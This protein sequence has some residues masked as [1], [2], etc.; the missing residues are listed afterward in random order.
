MIATHVLRYRCLSLLLVLLSSLSLAAEP[1]KSPSDNRDYR[2]LELDNGLKLLLIHSPDA[3]KAAASLE[4]SVGSGADPEPHAGLAHFLEHMLFLGTKKYPEAG[5]YQAYISQHGGRHNAFTAHDRTNYFFDIDQQ[6]LEPAL[7]RFAQFFISPLFTPEYVDRERHAV[8]SEYQS[9]LKDDG[10]RGY[11]TLRAALNPRH[12]LANFSVGSLETLTDHPG[13]PLLTALHRFYQQHYHANRMGLVIQGPQSLDQLQQWA[14][15]KFSAIPSGTTAAPTTREP[16]FLP[17]TLPAQLEVV[18]L[19]DIYELSATFPV[20]PFQAYWDKKPLQYLGALLGHEGTTSLLAELKR[21]G[22]AQGLSAGPGFDYADSATFTIHIDLTPAGL[23]QRDAVVELLFAT[24]ARIR[25]EDLQPWRYDEERLISETAFRF[26]EPAK[27]LYDVL[28]LA[29]KLRERPT[30][31]LLHGDYLYREFD[32]QL[33]DSYLQRLTP[34]NLL[35]TVTAQGLRG[36]QLEPRYQVSYKLQPISTERLQRWRQA[37][38]IAAIQLPEANPFLAEDFSLEPSSGMTIPQLIQEQPGFRLW[39]QQDDDF[40]VPRAN[41]YFTFRSPVAN[42]SARHHLMTALFVELVNDQLN[43]YLYPAS[44]AGFQTSLY[45]HIR[46][47][48]LRLSGYSDKQSPLLEAVVNQLSQLKIAPERL[49]IIREEMRQQ[50]QNRL[51]ATPYELAF[52]EL[53]QRLL[54]PSWSIAAQLDELDKIDLTALQQFVPQLLGRGNIE[55]LAHGNLSRQ[56]ALQ[57]GQ[58]LQRRLLSQLKPSAVAP[59]QAQLLAKGE[60]SRRISVDH[61]D[62][63]LIL[64][65]QGRDATLAERAQFA[66]LNQLFAAPFYTELR[67]EKQRGYV[68]FSTNHPVQEHAG[69][70][71]VVQSPSTSLAQLQQDMDHFLQHSNKLLEQLDPAQLER[72]QQSL[73]VSLLEQ[74]KKLSDRTGRYWRELDRDYVQFDSREQ[75]AAAIRAVTVEQL[76]ETYERLNERRLVIKAERQAP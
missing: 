1:L 39:Y 75:L 9:K 31:E 10:R 32:P 28:R 18:S 51:Q 37:E 43:S 4:V 20:P 26:K 30:A 47:F 60:E 52:D 16:L 14:K 22:W 49:E 45:P 71:L 58:V 29:G 7:D 35:L 73:L 57:L 63:A 70:A 74:E 33:I 54:A 72:L 17:G 34:D 11:A 56:E 64:Y 21:R 40:R 8:H 44:V 12:P 48:S 3:D 5:A 59:G 2:A 38:P 65:L 76:R 25:S 42:D 69:L 15:E 62:K 27:E 55:A 68:V 13:A 66:L 67:T 61:N 50:L 41:F 46:G 36:D 53:Q 24:I 6:Y 23:A 19:R